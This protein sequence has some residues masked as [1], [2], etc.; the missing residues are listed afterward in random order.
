MPAIP[1]SSG[2]QAMRYL[3]QSP[4]RTA[5]LGAGVGAAAGAL[6]PGEGNTRG[7]G[8]LTGALRGG[9][10]GGVGGGL[11]RGYRDTRLLNPNLSATGAIGATAKRMGQGT[12]DFAKRQ[13]HGFTGAFDHDAI[14]MAGTA[15]SARKADLLE[16]RMADELKH[17]PDE[18][19]KAIRDNFR[20]AID[21][22]QHEGAVAQEL[23]D[24]GATTLPG[25]AKAMVGKETRGRAFKA[26]GRAIT[27][28]PGG[29]MV[30]LGLPAALS[31]PPLLK[32][33]ESAQGGLT[34]GQKLRS[35]GVN[36]ATGVAFGGM[37]LI[38]QAAASIGAEAGMQRLTQRGSKPAPQPGEPLPTTQMPRPMIRGVNL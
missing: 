7:Q 20:G 24:A 21:A 10:I 34:T 38:P 15:R 30:S 17:A 8:A 14:G 29:A 37:P 25:L 4:A 36:L 12:L 35:A 22:T 19:H 9:V 6:R 3:T 13:V 23:A 16:R 32:G 18:A 1:L 11:G 28:T 31:I 26:M 2:M 5:M 33:D 27:D